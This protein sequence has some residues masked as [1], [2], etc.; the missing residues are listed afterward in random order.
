[1]SRPPVHH[2][3]CACGTALIAV[4]GRCR[5]CHQRIYYAANR[6]RHIATVRRYEAR[7]RELIR[8]KKAARHLA[9]YDSAKAKLERVMRPGRA[10]ATR[11]VYPQEVVHVSTPGW[12]VRV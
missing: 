5:R 10:P 9:T 12:G 7:N 11:T 4:K 2:D 1:V 6:E 8:C 3:P